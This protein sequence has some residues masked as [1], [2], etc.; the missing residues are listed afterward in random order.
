MRTEL[1]SFD[2]VVRYGG[3]EF[4]CALAGA[5]PEEAAARFDEIQEELA[6]DYDDAGISVGVVELHGRREPGRPH[7]PRR[8]RALRGQGPRAQAPVPSSVQA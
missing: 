3:D 4:I 2:P 7:L 1:R 5:D 8:R 6:R